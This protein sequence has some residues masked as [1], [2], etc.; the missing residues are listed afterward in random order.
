MSLYNT[1]DV[2]DYMK[3]RDA[4]WFIGRPK[5]QKPEPVDVQ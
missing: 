4:G 5:K 3:R 2:L 1:Q